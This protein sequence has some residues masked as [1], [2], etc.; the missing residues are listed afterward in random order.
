M[1][2][3][4]TYNASGQIETIT[5]ARD[6][7]TRYLYDA[8]GRIDE[9][10]LAELSTDESAFSF[11]YDAA[12]NITEVDNDKDDKTTFAGERSRPNRFIETFGATSDEGTVMRGKIQ[13]L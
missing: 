11:Q 9:V 3:D 12:G 10:I 5:D 1:T 13:S 8:V 2:I 6:Q 7:V 4:F